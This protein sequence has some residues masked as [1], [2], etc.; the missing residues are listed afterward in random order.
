MGRIDLFR[1]GRN[2]PQTKRCHRM[3]YQRF[4]ERLADL[5]GFQQGSQFRNTEVSQF[6]G[7]KL[8]LHICSYREQ[9]R[10]SFFNKQIQ[11]DLFA[12]SKQYLF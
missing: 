1:Q 5:K 10:Y 8:L 9:Y 11:S 4:R 7:R 12:N 3:E 2:Q 6:L